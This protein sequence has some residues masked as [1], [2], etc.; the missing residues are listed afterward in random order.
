MRKEESVYVTNNGEQPFRDRY[1][2][3]D[4]VI[5]PGE[6]LDMPAPCARLVFGFGEKDKGRAIRR[7]GWAKTASDMNDALARLRTFSFGMSPPPVTA[8]EKAAP[9]KSSSQHAPR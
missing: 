7:L 4:F 5:H 3:E 2:G 9:E 1:D 8:L 6:T